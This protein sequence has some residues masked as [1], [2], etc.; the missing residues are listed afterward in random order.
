MVGHQ[1]SCVGTSDP[2]QKSNRINNFFQFMNVSTETAEI[3]MF[4]ILFLFLFFSFCYLLPVDAGI[5][6][7][8]SGSSL[9]IN[10][11]QRK[12]LPQDFL[13][14]FQSFK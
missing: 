9:G 5:L 2:P 11:P 13:F 8:Y 12:S 1:S 10:S 14:M 3:E 6:A 4:F 7:Q